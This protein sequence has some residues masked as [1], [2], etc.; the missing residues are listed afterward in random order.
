MLMP[1]KRHMQ[2][3]AQWTVLAY[4]SLRPLSSWVINLLQRVQQLVDWTADLSVPKTVWISG[5]RL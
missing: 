1:K 2:V 5:R 3:P 4:P